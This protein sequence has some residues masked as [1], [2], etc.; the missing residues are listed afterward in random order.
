MKKMRTYSSDIGGQGFYF[1]FFKRAV[2]EAR[3]DVFCVEFI[4]CSDWE[5]DERGIWA[6]GDVLFAWV[7][8]RISWTWSE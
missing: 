1:S 3:E 2:R 7:S 8:A 6:I 4:E 5:G